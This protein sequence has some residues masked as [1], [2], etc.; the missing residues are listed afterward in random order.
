MKGRFLALNCAAIPGDL[1]ENQLFG[2]RKGSFTG[3]DRDQ[4]GIFL[5][6]AAGTVFLDEIGELAL[7]TQAKLLRAIEQKEVMPV[8]ANEPVHFEARIVAATNK[9]LA[10]EAELGRFREDLFYRLNVVSLRLRRRCASAGKI[11]PS[12][13]NSCLPSTPSPS[14]SGSRGASHETMQL[15]LGAPWKGNIRQLD[16][17]LQRAVIFCESSLIEPIDL[18]PDLM[19]S[20]SAAIQVDDLGKAMERFERL[21]LE[22]I[23]R[24][25][26]R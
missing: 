12:L 10:R 17:A 20:S 16:N 15:L 1:I 21:H 19:P 25:T 9:D 13:S 26:P 23:L 22:R 5:H 24:E 6:A 7:P 8:G 4:P 2:H 11:F 3:A 18:P 14:A